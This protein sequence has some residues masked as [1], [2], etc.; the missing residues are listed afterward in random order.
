M[1]TVRRFAAGDVI[2]FPFTS[3]AGYGS[4][5]ALVKRNSTAYN[6]IIGAG[7]WPG[8]GIEI[9]VESNTDGNDF[10]FDSLGVSYRAYTTLDV[11]NADGWVM[12]G[13]S[14]A[15]G[16]SAPVGHRRV[17]STGTWTHSTHGGGGLANWNTGMSVMGLGKF[18]VDGGDFVGDY[19]LMAYWDGTSLS[20]ATYETFTS[21]ANIIAASPTALYVLDQGDTSI[22]VQDQIGTR[23]QSSITGTSVVS[24]TIPNFSFNEPPNVVM[25]V[26]VA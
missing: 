22:A 19:A 10:V 26:S 6:T 4:F 23:H 13:A 14:K 21:V 7:T 20:N 3:S 17:Q 16:S 1:S 18:I 11:V 5:L 8:N 25:P 9:I 2:N 24:D 12:L 15:T